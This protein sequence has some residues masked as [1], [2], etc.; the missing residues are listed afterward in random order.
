MKVIQLKAHFVAALSN[1]GSF[2]EDRFRTLRAIALWLLRFT[3]N[4][5]EMWIA[6]LI[7]MLAFEYVRQGLVIVGD[8]S[9]L[10]P[11]SIQSE[12]GHGVF[13]AAPMV[14]WMRIRG[15][16]WRENI[17]MTLGMIVPWLA[18]LALGELDVLRRLLWLSE[19][20]AMAAGMLAVMLYQ[21]ACA[22]ANRLKEEDRRLTSIPKSSRENQRRS[23]IETKAQYPVAANH[24]SE[25]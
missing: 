17:E 7:G 1:N 13:M 23:A 6:M 4:F 18:V 3:L 14:F 5:V 8:W 12:V 11:R 25:L 10:N 15:Y 22:R 9:F 21:A 2:R 20:N 19:R 16:R 24:E